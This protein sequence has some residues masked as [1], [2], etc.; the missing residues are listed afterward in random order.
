[1][2]KAGSTAG[3]LGSLQIE[4]STWFN[5]VRV[6]DSHDNRTRTAT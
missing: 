6:D 4:N 3:L 1:L 2:G 5:N